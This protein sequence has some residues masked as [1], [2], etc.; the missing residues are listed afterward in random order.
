MNAILYALPT[1]IRWCDLPHD[2]GD[3]STAHRCFQ[4]WQEDGTWKRIWLEMLDTLDEEDK[5]DCENALL[6]G[7]FFRQKGGP[8]RR[9]WAKRQSVDLL[10]EGHG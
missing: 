4:R 10:T 3:D 1:G 2:L 9:L 5:L 6:D 8:R 7:S